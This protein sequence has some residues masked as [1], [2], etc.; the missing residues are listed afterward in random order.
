MRNPQR[1]KTK[2]RI[3]AVLGDE[4]A[5]Q[6]YKTLLHKTHSITQT[7]DAR[8]YVFYADYINRNDLWDEENFLKEL[9]HGNDLGEKMKHAFNDVFSKG[10]DEVII[11]GSDCYDL[12]AAII[13][14]AFAALSQAEVVIG[15]A[16]DGGYYLLGMNK[17]YDLFDDIQ[18]SS[19]GVLR[20]T[21]LKAHA[22]KLSVHL[23]P[24]LNDVD[25]AADITF[26]Y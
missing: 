21:Q 18:W 5:L 17:Y 6:V 25:E 16:K 1:G 10:F 11:I 3:A 19:A 8:K 13:S 22:L 9:Q 12:T 24:L 20:A 4:A 7:I 23:V 14:E 2:T 15:P 26:D